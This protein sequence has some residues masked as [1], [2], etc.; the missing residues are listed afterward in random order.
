[1]FSDTDSDSHSDSA[2]D[3]LSVSVSEQRISL[4]TST[5]F[6]VFQVGLLV[7]TDCDL[8]R[9]EA[10]YTCNNAKL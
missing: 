2:S 10:G 4:E 6:M 1:M 5:M 3:S 7:I 8:K 9:H